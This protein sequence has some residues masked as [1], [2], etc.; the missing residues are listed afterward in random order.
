MSGLFSDG[1]LK[2][3]RDVVSKLYTDTFD[4]WRFEHV[5]EGN[6]YGQVSNLIYE[7]VPCHLSNDNDY[8]MDVP[9]DLE[10][11][12]NVRDSYTLFAGADVR[13]RAGDRVCVYTK[14]GS[15]EGIVG[16]SFVRDVGTQTRL[17]SR[18]I[19]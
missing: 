6:V 8:F 14:G 9:D 7:G 13:L 4:A 11:I 18:R 3:M 2:M 1:D 12:P 5:Q 15:V 10:D 17:R 16:T 19:V